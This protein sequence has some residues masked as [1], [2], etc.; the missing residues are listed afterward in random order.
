[1]VS[2]HFNTIQTHKNLTNIQEQSIPKITLLR[3]L[4]CL[5]TRLD[6]ARSSVA[7]NMRQECEKHKA[8][9]ADFFSILSLLSEILAGLVFVDP[10]TE[11]LQAQPR[12]RNT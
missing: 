2:S 10:W 1:M 4:G 8:L 3:S 7:F 5:K 9:A 11:T 6:L 12:F